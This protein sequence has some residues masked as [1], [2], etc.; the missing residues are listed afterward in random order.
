MKTALLF[1]FIT[2]AFAMIS[3]TTSPKKQSNADTWAV[4]INSKELLASWLDNEIGDT[5]ILKRSQLKDR[6][7]LFIQ[8]YL[9]GQTAENT[10]TYLLI[11]NRHGERI[12]ATIA[13]NEGLMFRSY[14]EMYELLHSSQIRTGSVVGVHCAIIDEMDI[15]GEDELLCYIK[16]EE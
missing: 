15:Q 8:R 16:F 13:A 11:T 12:A 4:G 10:M 5:L 6:D 14:L 9:C 2:I 3:S 1:S 7:T